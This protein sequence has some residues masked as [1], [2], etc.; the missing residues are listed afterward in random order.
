[1]ELKIH[2]LEKRVM[3]DIEFAAQHTQKIE[4][5]FFKRVSSLEVEVSQLKAEMRAKEDVIRSLIAR[6]PNLQDTLVS[7]LS[8]TNE[9]AFNATG[10]KSTVSVEDERAVISEVQP[11][12]KIYQSVMPKGGKSNGP[13][14]PRHG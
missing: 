4:G 10:Q 1:M 5:E 2:H 9:N 6:G 7:I 14:E 3:Q 11:I 13:R 12:Q 8:A